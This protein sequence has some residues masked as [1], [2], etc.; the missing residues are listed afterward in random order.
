MVGW[1]LFYIGPIL[2]KLLT[3]RLSHV[4]FNSIKKWDH[5]KEKHD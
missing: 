3:Y 4:S 5:Y 1:V 2:A